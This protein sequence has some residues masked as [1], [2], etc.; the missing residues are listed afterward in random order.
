M[1]MRR[2]TGLD[3]STT[4]V[5]WITLGVRYWRYSGGM[6]KSQG[7]LYIKLYFC[8]LYNR[9]MSDDFILLFLSNFSMEFVKSDLRD[10]WWTRPYLFE[11]FSGSCFTKDESLGFGISG[12]GRLN[13]QAASCGLIIMGDHGH[14]HDCVHIVVPWHCRGR[15][16][17]LL[18]RMHQK[19]D[20]GGS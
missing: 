1:A 12:V 13:S 9:F 4:L 15:L 20:I 5:W 7:G 16:R 18:Y 11:C 8:I 14:G 10:G 19:S 17:R 2:I 6:D 3:L